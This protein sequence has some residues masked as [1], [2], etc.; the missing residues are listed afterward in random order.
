MALIR[1]AGDWSAP[2]YQR[3]GRDV[4]TLLF[5]VFAIGVAVMAGLVSATGEPVYVVIFSGL[6][7][8]AMV[9][10]SR[11]SL[12]WFVIIGGLVI[13]GLAQLY[14]PGARYVRYVIPLAALILLLH[15]AVER[16]RYPEA[17]GSGKLTEFGGWA[18][19]FLTIAIASALINQ[20]G[21]A[22]AVNGLRGY[23]Q[24]WPFL[25]AVLLIR[26]APEELR[27]WPKGLLIVGLLQIPFI[28]HQYLVLVPK[29]YA[30]MGDGLVPVDIV[31]GTF[32]GDM[33]GGGAN[34]VLAGFMIV[35]TAC[36]AGLWKYK[37]IST[38]A[39]LLL[40]AI[41]MSPVFVNEAKISAVYL[42]LVFIIIFY[43]DVVQR[44][45]R[46]L[47][48]TFVMLGILAGLLTALTATHTSGEMENWSDLVNWTYER[49]TADISERRGE[50]SELTRWTVLT[51]WFDEH[52]D[53]NP[54][55]TLIGHGPGASRVQESGY[56]QAESLAEKRY[57]GLK[58][59]HTAVGALLWDIGIVGLGVV[60]LMFFSA[61]RSA[62]WLSRHYEHTDPVLAGLFVGL[63]AG[64]AVLTLSLAHKDFFVVNL[65][66]QTLIILV[67]GFVLAYRKLAE[68]TSGTE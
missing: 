20:E 61:F 48:A 27:A 21:L 2:G 3:L 10:S 57:G 59:G 54:A 67:F 23:F 6:V 22:V 4:F 64:I 7:V 49:Q 65:P 51:F 11:Q 56:D 39:A 19:M 17:K 46:F 60:L 28:L 1:T 18:T 13:T 32:G 68:E 12:T 52:K 37:A 55:Y 29:R 16:I 35:L 53:A 26:W 43:K 63:Q 50:F 44:P 41:F 9:V 45:L 40:S 62:A 36:V 14:M 33:F 34:A 31:V 5:Y 38:W 8:G 25:A 58:I 66:F 42:P 47:A 30:L 15:A 24:M